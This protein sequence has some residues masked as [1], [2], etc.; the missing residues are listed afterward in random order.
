MTAAIGIGVSRRKGLPGKRHGR[1]WLEAQFRLSLIILAFVLS[2]GTLG[3]MVVEGWGFLDALYMTIITLST[4]GFTEVHPLSSVG[5]VLSM[6]IIVTGVGSAGFAV[7]TI[8]RITLED[9]IRD[10]FGRRFMKAIEKLRDHYIVCGYGR[11]GRVICEE[12]AS[13]DVPFVVIEV[14]DD[15]LE[16]LEK[17][18]FLYLKGDAT[19]D[20]DLIAAGIER[21]AGLISVVTE[22]TQNVF[23][24][25]TARGLNPKLNIVT[26][27]ATEENIKKLVRAG[28]NKVVSPYFVGGHRI[29][30][31]VMRP[32][33]LDFLETIVQNR[34]MDLRLEEARVSPQSPLVGKTLVDSGLRKD[35]NII[36]FAVKGPTGSM[37]FNPSP[38]T[39]FKAGDTLVILGKTNDLE[40][41]E[42]IVKGT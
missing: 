39:E 16:E 3:F 33:V 17:E 10:A 1:E 23:I 31:A 11:M 28:A 30:Q 19:D 9:R 42:R 15:A 5:K 8:A 4:V 18:S 13:R 12:L 20:E 36:L 26:R 40:V 7:G 24:V 35:F 34:E 29:A 41:F 37:I 14:G 21:A 2:G 27:A 6:G 38:D 32:T 25:L 22:D